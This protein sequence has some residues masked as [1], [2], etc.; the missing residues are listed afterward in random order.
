MRPEWCSFVYSPLPLPYLVV[1]VIVSYVYNLPRVKL[2]LNVFNC[3][4]FLRDVQIVSASFAY[5]PSLL[6]DLQIN[7]CYEYPVSPMPHIMNVYAYM[8]HQFSSL[9]LSSCNGD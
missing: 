7:S 8:P 1:M 3:C 9:P 2:D 6:N 5:H 4:R